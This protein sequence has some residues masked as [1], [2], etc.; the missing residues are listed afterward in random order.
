MNPT[1]ARLFVLLEGRPSPGTAAWLSHARA[2]L[3]GAVDRAAFVDGF[4]AASRR[5]GK[6][7]V[8]L[9]EA[10]RAAVEDLPLPQGLTLDELGRI[11]ML[12]AL[13]AA[14]QEEL[15]DDCFRRGETRERRAVLRALPLLPRPERFVSLAVGACRTHVLPVFEAICCENPYPASCFP[16]AS[17]HQMVLKALFLEVALDRILGLRA[18]RTPELDRMAN[19]YAS[20]RRAAGRS[21]PTD[22]ERHFNADRGPAPRSP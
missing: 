1:A 18:R 4:A 21:V 2:G 16:D 17:F 5:L 7:E 15:A 19:D 3:A 14:E 12:A 6:A 22:I 8:V 20:E 13:P 11:A 10:E 9:T